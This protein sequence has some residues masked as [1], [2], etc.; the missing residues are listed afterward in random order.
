MSIISAGGAVVGAGGA[1]AAPYEIERS[2]R[3]NSAD[4][5]YLN[6]TP[7]VAGNRQ[8]WTWSAWVKL[9][10]IGGSYSMFYGD[11]SGTSGAETSIHFDASAKIE[12]YIRGGQE[13]LTTAVFRDPSAWYH[14]VWA[15]DTTQA[16]NTDRQKLY[17]NGV[18]ITSFSTQKTITLD[19]ETGINNTQPQY[20]GSYG[21]YSFWSGYQT[22]VHLIDGQQL[23]ASSFGEFNATTGVWQ[24]KAYTGSYGTNG[25]Y[26]N[27]SDNS[28]ATAATLGADSSGNGNNWTPNGFVV[29][30][31]ASADNDS[32]VD[33]P[34]PYGTDT[35]VGGEVRGNYGTYDVLTPIGSA[36]ALAPILNGNLQ[37]NG[38]GS[39]YAQR[40]GNFRVNSGKW[41][42]EWT[43]VNVGFPSL[44][45]GWHSSSSY[46]TFGGGGGQAT[47]G[48]AVGFFGG[49]TIYLSTFS[50]GFA[51]TTFAGTAWAA[52]NVIMIAIDLDA[53]K[54][55]GGR[56]GVW[57]Q[58]GDPSNDL[59]PQ[60]TWTPSLSLVFAPWFIGYGAATDC[61]ANFGQRPFDHAAP[62][63]FQALVTTNI[64][65]GTVTTSGSFTGNT[66]T[67]GPFVYL[68]GVPTAMTINGNAVTFGTD[69]DKLANGFKVRSSSSSY[70]ASGSNAYSVSTTGEVFKNEVAQPNP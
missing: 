25:F 16:S 37:F 11:I 4:S 44:Q 60:D 39:N 47:G 9:G 1:A 21:A 69:A 42:Y 5:A 38:A 53:G 61:Y 49:S 59:N 57:Y 43:L 17:V 30:P 31:V 32:L 68:N 50:G 40:F 52:T 34:T 19:F 63:G 26:L 58:S 20:I 2:L 6:R 45:C 15:V 54:F 27:F 35:G 29:S 56:D 23:D 33:T 48:S 7:A 14:I 12:L 36:A 66:A 28:G 51:A 24:P 22:E 65:A 18:Q 67:D 3:F 41:Y 55:W 64:P 62:T 13:W 8:T 70:N 10:V 46:P